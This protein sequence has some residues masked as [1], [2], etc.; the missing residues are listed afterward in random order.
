MVAHV[1][2]L[3]M[4]TNP[5][6]AEMQRVFHAQR[7]GFRAH[8]MPTLEDRLL[9]LQRLRTSLLRYKDDL[10]QS[11]SADFGHRSSDETLFAEV[12]T[13][14]ESI[15]YHER[16]LA[17]WMRPQKRSVNPLHLPAKAR[18]VY[19]PLGVVGVIV[20]WNYPVFLALG[21]LTAAVAAGNR[22]MIKMSGF[23]P[24]TASVMSCLLA[25]VASPDVIAVCA[26]RGE[27]SEAFA[28]LPFDQLTFTGST[29][30]GKKI[31]AAAAEHLTPVLLELGGKSPAIIHDSYPVDTAAGRIAFG[32]CWNAG[33][34]C[35][36]PDYVICNH[37]RLQDFVR[38]MQ[39]HVQA[40]YPTMRENPDYTAI[41]NEK[42]HSRLKNLLQD[43]RQKGATLVEINPGHDDFSQ[44]QKMP[45][46]LI[47]GV[48]PE[49]LV[50]QQEIFGPILPVMGVTSLDEALE[51]VRHRPRPLALYYFDHHPSRIAFVSE[52]THSG[53]LGV[54]EVLSHVGI[55]DLPFGGVGASGMGRYHAH[56]GFLTY[57]NAKAVLEKSRIYP[58][59]YFL[60]PFNK[61]LHK[62]LKSYFLR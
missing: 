4:S 10:V 47:L 41:I 54:N 9:V 61:G 57:S 18:V 42:Q 43:A 52:Q 62:F 44:T 55:E 3:E 53:G 46:T 45:L 16:H 23:T 48:T 37:S 8:P 5:D 1:V 60:P 38:A 24:A 49:M 13:T 12:M 26:G 39:K 28:R 6:V 22:V 59:H 31:M 51:F 33:Q 19:Q 32:K 58:L 34:T 11:V 15:K 25:E 50:M 30:V 2:V 35:V 36:A 7:N 40:M 17:Q 56:E 21:P 14:L 27:I 29:E 20:P